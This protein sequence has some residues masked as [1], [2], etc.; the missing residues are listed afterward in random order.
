MLSLILKIEI[1]GGPGGRH[2]KN[3][4]WA[5]GIGRRYISANGANSRQ[6][7]RNAGEMAFHRPYSTFVNGREQQAALSAALP[8]AARSLSWHLDNARLVASET[9]I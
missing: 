5:Q 1:G 2:E 9:V 7:C 4:R 6:A 3:F 8:V